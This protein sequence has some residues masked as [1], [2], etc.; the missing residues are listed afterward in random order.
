MVTNQYYPHRQSWTVK[1]EGLVTRNRMML[2]D[3]DEA[4]FLENISFRCLR[5][6]AWLVWRCSRILLHS[7]CVISLQNGEPV[8]ESG[9]SFLFVCHY[10]CKPQFWPAL[11]LSSYLSRLNVAEC[12][13]DTDGCFG[14]AD[15]SVRA[16]NLTT[17]PDEWLSC[18]DRLQPHCDCPMKLLAHFPRFARL[19]NVIT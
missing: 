19:H 7:W 6:K 17:W 9:W 10:L 11:F 13:S 2:A 12:M 8:V 14:Q 5:Q 4:V 16:H 15:L 1:A 3:R 18:S